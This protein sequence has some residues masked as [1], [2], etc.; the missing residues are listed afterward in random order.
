MKSLY[1]ILFLLF[2]LSISGC[3]IIT[4][5][6]ATNKPA[7]IGKDLVI[8]EVFTL[9]PDKYYNYSWIEVYNPNNIMFN[10]YKVVKPAIGVVVGADGT[11]R[12]TNNTGDTWQVVTAPTTQKLNAVSFS[13]PDS[14]VIVGDS[15]TILSIKKSGESWA[16]RQI[17]FPDSLK[18]KNLRDVH[19][20]DQAKGGFL[21]GDSGL[22]M[23]SLDRGQTWANFFGKN[24]LKYNLNSFFFQSTA[25][26]FIAGD[27][28]TILKSTGSSTWTLKPIPEVIQPKTNFYSV[29]MVN[30]SNGYV[31]GEGGV[32]LKTVNIG[33]T[34]GYKN[35][36]VT[37]TLRSVFSS[38]ETAFNINYAWA[39]GDNGV[40]LKSTDYGEQWVKQNSGITATIRKIAFVDSLRGFA[41]CDGGTIITTTNGGTNWA[42]QES[43]SGSPIMGYFF[44]YPNIQIV[45]MYALEMWGVRKHFL[46]NVVIA[47]PEATVVNYDYITK[48]DTGII[49][50]NPSLYAQL[51][52]L[53]YNYI[54]IKTSR[55]APIP[56]QLMDIF[57]AK[58]IPSIGAGA[59]TIIN[60]DS[61]K[62]SNHITEGP[63]VVN[64]V[65]ANIGYD[66]NMQ[67]PDTTKPFWIDWFRWDL[68]PSS[69][70][71]LVSYQYTI[72]TNTQEFLGFAK[73]TVDVVRWG[74][75]KP[76]VWYSPGDSLYPNHQPA[77]F[78]PEWYSLSRYSDDV[79]D[80]EKPWNLNTAT[81]FFM[82]KDP[83]PG[84]Y[85]QKKKP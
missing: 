27:S 58:V 85:S 74:N 67:Q 1:A 30:D 55:F 32:I 31:V 37:T 34:W 62:Y 79:G 6:G 41:F 70:I 61:I 23:R 16:T 71:R 28:G 4:E 53:W 11:I 59:F 44:N 49:S 17:R 77:G 45:N 15:G 2:L 57:G 47:A 75:F 72:N 82:A 14:G 80:S 84:W 51:P 73:K 8:N 13:L 50:F 40:I 22:I 25:L 33:D 9:S 83:L 12:F 48:V 10:W 39:A 52:S 5:K 19:L 7:G 24:R 81:S 68:L 43:N 29:R 21:I 54:A 46:S 66:Y 20:I 35:S 64:V 56:T 36:N 18:T 65:N 76:T 3:E 78:I 26:Y 38:R 42:S 60:N 63:G 69:E